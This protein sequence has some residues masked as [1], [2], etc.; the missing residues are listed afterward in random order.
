M[1]NIFPI[2]TARALLVRTALFALLWAVLTEG[3]GLVSV[4][5]LP[6]I[7]AGVIVS[8]LLW[9][10]K[11]WKWRFR[12]AVRFIP[13]FFWHSFLGGLDVAKRALSPRIQIRPEIIDFPFILEKEPARVVFLWAVSLLPGT[14]GVD[15]QE[16][17]ARIHILDTGI[18]DVTSLRVLESRIA[19]MFDQQI[20]TKNP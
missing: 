16:N 6:G 14:A 5:T 7:G 1:R 20:S 10:S 12:P 18:A 11:D 15:L 8:F 13:Y 9:P 4:W 2:P 17:T 19:A 3:E